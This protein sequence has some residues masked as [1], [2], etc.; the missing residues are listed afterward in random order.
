MIAQV[1][2]LFFLLLENESVT[3]EG[4]QA[5]IW[6]VENMMDI[7]AKWLLRASGSFTK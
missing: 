2:H 5:N 6:Y 7:P 4:W 3:N 1:S